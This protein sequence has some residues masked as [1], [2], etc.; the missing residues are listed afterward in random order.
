VT[1]LAFGNG[2]PDI[3]SALA[4]INQPNIKRAS[5]AFGALFGAGM[6]VTTIV[7][8]AVVISK[9]FML[10][11]RPYMRDLIFYLAA[12]YWTF[13][14]LWNN[15][16]NIFN[17]LGFIGLYICYVLVV[18]FGRLIYQKFKTKKQIG[19]GDIPKP[20]AKQE[21]QELK[22]GSNSPSISR[23]FSHLPKPNGRIISQEQDKP[24]IPRDHSPPPT[25]TATDITAN[26]PAV[27]VASG[28]PAVILVEASCDIGH[29][30]DHKAVNEEG[31]E[32]SH[33]LSSRERCAS[34][35]SQ[36]V[37]GVSDEEDDDTMGEGGQ[38]IPPRKRRIRRTISGALDIT[39]DV[40]LVAVGTPN[41]SKIWHQ[42]YK[43]ELMH[44]GSGRV[45]PRMRRSPVS[46]DHHASRSRAS[47]HLGMRY[48]RM[49]NM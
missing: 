16:M 30:E 33:L 29:T 42:A 40:G 47:S 34:R 25:I 12:V 23:L 27:G 43:K 20:P 24:D 11:R 6:F 41:L 26:G 22:I 8:G 17:S 3:F 5:L 36:H 39:E 1:L 32:S 37:Y 45:S 9:P 48:C 21:G 7:V 4:A 18:I 15:E 28:I 31:Q 35:A 10:T 19:T 2:A 49:R 13:F 14:V 38:P 44:E 46:H